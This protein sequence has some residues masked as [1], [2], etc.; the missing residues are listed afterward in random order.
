M[1]LVLLDVA[2][3]VA[4]AGEG[5]VRDPGPLVGDQDLVGDEAH[6]PAGLYFGAQPRQGGQALGADLLPPSKTIV[7]YG[8][9]CSPKR[10]NNEAG[11]MSRA[12]GP[13][14]HIRAFGRMQP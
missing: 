14:I 1:R 3:P 13:V 9:E 8:H 11:D 12:P 2:G 5:A 7:R 10:I 4:Q 6:R